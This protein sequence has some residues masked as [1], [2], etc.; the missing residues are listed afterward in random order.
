VTLHKYQSNI[1][2]FIRAVFTYCKNVSNE[3]GNLKFHCHQYTPKTFDL[4][5][6]A[7]KLQTEVRKILLF[8]LSIV[9]Y[10]QMYI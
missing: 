10:V 6:A 2:L 8:K 9:S 4:Q 3:N 5:I 1:S 7:M